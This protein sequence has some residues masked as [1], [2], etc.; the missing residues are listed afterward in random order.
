MEN[1]NRRDWGFGKVCSM[2]IFPPQIRCLQTC[3]LFLVSF[4]SYFLWWLITALLCWISPPSLS[5]ADLA[6]GKLGILSLSSFAACTQVHPPLFSPPFGGMRSSPPLQ[7]NLSRPS[8]PRSCLISSSL[9]HLSFCTISSIYRHAQGSHYKQ[10]T[11]CLY[12]PSCHQTSNLPFTLQLAKVKLSFL[13][14]SAVFLTDR[15]TLIFAKCAGHFLV[16]MFS[17]ST[18]FDTDDYSFSP[19]GI[20]YPDTVSPPASLPVSFCSPHSVF[21][22]CPDLLSLLSTPFWLIASSLMAI[23]AI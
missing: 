15:S 8:I 1:I 10:I 17:D 23:E 13:Y 21:A 3:C 22:G 19:S 6:W 12:A 9:F 7:A 20:C 16:F 18:A 2:Q 4:L 14:H 11:F 5:A